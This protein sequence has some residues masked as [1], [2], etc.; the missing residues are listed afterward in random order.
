[1][2]TIGLV[3]N[4]QSLVI[5]AKPKL[6]SGDQNTVKVHVDFSD[7]WNGFGK[8][9]VFFTERDRDIIYEKV[10]FSGE[11]TVPAEVTAESGILFIGVRGVNSN[12]KEVKTTSLVRYK[13]SEG[14]PNGN[15][16]EIEPTPSV[17][18]QLLT[19]VAQIDNLIQLKDGSTTGDA[20]LQDIRVGYDGVT[21]DTAGTSVRRQFK[22]FDSINFEKHLVGIDNT[23]NVM[24][25]VPDAVKIDLDQIKSYYKKLNGSISDD[26]L[27]NNLNTYCK[28]LFVPKNVTSVTTETIFLNFQNLSYIVF[29]NVVSSYG[30]SDWQSQLAMLNP[31]TERIYLIDVENYSSRVTALLKMFALERNNIENVENQV[32]NLESDLKTLYTG[33]DVTKTVSYTVGS[34]LVANDLFKCKIPKGMN[35]K[36][37]ITTSPAGSISVIAI[38]K[39][40]SGW[41][42]TTI[43]SSGERSVEY[44]ADEEIN[45]INIRTDAENISANGTL[46]VTLTTSPNIQQNTSDIQQNTSD[47]QQNTSDIQQVYSTLNGYAVSKE[48][49]VTAGVEITATVTNLVCV[50]PKGMKYTVSFDVSTI[51]AIKLIGLRRN[52]KY[53]SGVYL[54]L[55]NGH[56]EFSEV[57][58]EDI[59]QF[60]FVSNADL[61]KS[62]CTVTM[63]IS[64]DGLKEQVNQNASDIQQVYSTLNGYAKSN[65]V[66][67]VSLSNGNKSELEQTMIEMNTSVSAVVNFDTFNGVLSFGRNLNDYRGKSYEIDNTSVKK[68]IWDYVTVD[69]STSLQKVLKNTYEHGLTLK[70]PLSMNIHTVDDNGV[71]TRKFTLVNGDGDIYTIDNDSSICNGTPFIMTNGMSI[72][73]DT[74]SFI[75]NMY[76]RDL[77]VYGDSYC[78][79]YWLPKIRKLG[80]CNFLMDLRSGESTKQA[81]PCFK[82]ALKHGKP[83][84]VLWAEGMNNNSDVDE[85]TP[86][87]TWL[88]HTQEMIELCEINGIVPIL[89]TT[90]SVYYNNSYI[91]NHKGKNAWIKNSG[92]RYVDFASILEDGNGNWFTGLKDNETNGV[93]P[94]VKGSNLLM[95]Y[96]LAHIPEFKSN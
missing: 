49:E 50:I 30:S 27:I 56:A 79:G 1:M 65:C 59:Y 55:L 4:D 71:V 15:A 36:F 17:Y 76:N 45:S 25:S 28:I 84:F 42:Y 47:I 61:V 35:V 87:P 67:K 38:M 23:G 3:A 20:E 63:T 53:L 73:I 39:N 10:L 88:N 58:Q 41:K 95:L 34:K 81:L 89:V 8:S 19:G 54:S 92:Y 7:D 31:L 22:K 37:D 5:N 26:L 2:T 12:N 72:T 29:D 16:T 21:S 14:T 40:G 32:T 70:S 60:A 96:A 80:F 91:K 74:F 77:W 62:D 90:P 86:N 13:I 24:F 68:Y 57:A 48:I 75:T 85:N 11:C 44:V 9:A 64:Y 52:T 33:L 6:S 69:G 82:N 46:T 94:S 51:N 66:S 43:P 93:H 83:K 78:E 18:Q